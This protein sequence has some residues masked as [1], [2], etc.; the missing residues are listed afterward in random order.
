MGLDIGN[1]H[2][3]VTTE[4]NILG[5]GKSSR[6]KCCLKCSQIPSIVGGEIGGKA[7][8][9]AVGCVCLKRSVENRRTLGGA[10]R[11]ASCGTGHRG[12]AQIQVG[13]AGESDIADVGRECNRACGSVRG[14]IERGA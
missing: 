5:L 2:C 14:R 10:E 9:R 6:S 8:G 12:S 7:S 3:C 13:P 1:A 11:K 4:V